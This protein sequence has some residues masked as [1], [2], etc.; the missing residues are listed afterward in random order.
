MN[1]MKRIESFEAS[2]SMISG[3]GKIGYCLWVDDSGSLYV[4]MI[5]NSNGGTLNKYLYSIS[6]YIDKRYQ[7][8]RW[9]IVEGVCPE[10]FELINIEKNDNQGGFL[11]AVLRH[12]FPK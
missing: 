3:S 11:K 1:S 10:T 2:A 7:K 12:M 5:S 4:Q 6:K 8:E 9:N